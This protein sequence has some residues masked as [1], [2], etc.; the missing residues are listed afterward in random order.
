MIWALLIYNATNNPS[1]EGGVIQQKLLK[2]N[3]S[4]DEGL[5]LYTVNVRQLGEHPEF[6]Y[7]VYF[8]QLHIQV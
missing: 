5:R 7:N 1:L 8:T 3:E 2:N 4:L 6:F